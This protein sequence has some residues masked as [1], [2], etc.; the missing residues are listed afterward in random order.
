MGIQSERMYREY[1]DI[2]IGNDKAIF[3]SSALMFI[4]KEFSTSG[5]K[6]L[7]YTAYGH[8]TGGGTAYMTMTAL[9]HNPMFYHCNGA[10][11]SVTINSSTGEA[12]FD[13]IYWK[14]SYRV[15]KAMPRKAQI[16]GLENGVP[17]NAWIG[18]KFVVKVINE[19]LV[20]L[21]LYLDLTR[22]QN[23][24]AWQLVHQ[25]YDSINTWNADTNSLWYRYYVKSS[26]NSYGKVIT[27][28]SPYCA[29]QTHGD[30]TKQVY[31]K[32]VS[33]RNILNENS[34]AAS[35]PHVWKD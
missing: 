20:T 23:G 33:I 18:I 26:C 17:P 21:E 35:C 22:G 5:Y 29:L 32:N 34:E 3:T 16:F 1:G 9:L 6:N 7:E 11:Y 24:G 27:G 31:W 10:S 19:G 25:T 4:Q 8:H 30:K 28:P 2:V 12:I 15:V 14:S 13:K